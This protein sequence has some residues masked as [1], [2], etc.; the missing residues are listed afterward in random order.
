MLWN[1]SDFP[2]FQVAMAPNIA[3][4]AMGAMFVYVLV[5]MKLIQVKT[6]VETIKSD[7]CK[8]R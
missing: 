4:F 8:V 1:V 7:L 2:P 3:E 5:K 6:K